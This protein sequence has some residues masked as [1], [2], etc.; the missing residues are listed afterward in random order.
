MINEWKDYVSLLQEKGTYR[1]RLKTLDKD[2][3]AY[4]D[5]GPQKKGSPYK[6]KRTSFKKKKFNDISA[7]PGAPGGLEEVE[8]DRSG[9]A[10]HDEL[11][12]EIWDD[13]SIKPDIAERLR[14]IAQDF[15]ETLDVPV[16]MK[17]LRVTGSLANYNWSK[18][19]DVDLHLVVDFGDV[20]EDQ[21]LVK[22]YFDAARARWNDLHDIKIMGYDV[23]IYVENVDEEH[24]STGVY[25]LLNDDWKAHPK[26]LKHKIDF[27]TAIKKAEDIEKRYEQAKE[28]YDEGEYD[29]VLRTV[30]RI[31]AKIR[32][33]RLAGLESEEMEL[34]AENVAFKILRSA[35]ILHKLSRLKY[36]AY[37]RSMSMSDQ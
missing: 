16:E 36:N 15:L 20:D 6:T 12:P 5:T 10:I 29:K 11:E 14:L 35:K 28:V 24:R 27:E 23:E 32:D 25:S 7:P 33:M 3:G 2:M 26:M 22:A 19:S 17:D 1:N 13:G 31:K 4:L 34:S 21:E 8:V 30:E 9:F 18:Y 37:D